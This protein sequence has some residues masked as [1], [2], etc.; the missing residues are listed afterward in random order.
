MSDGWVN[1]VIATD[2]REKPLRNAQ[3]NLERLGISGVDLRLCDGLSL[4]NSNEA[5]TVIIAGMGGE[6]IAGII[7]RAPWLKARGI[8]LILQAMTSAEALRDYLADNGF[9]IEKE[10]TLEE[11]GK[12]YSVILARFDGDM[13]RISPAFRYVGAVKNIT[14]SDKRYIQ[15]Q[16]IRLNSCAES[17]KGIEAQYERY[18]E[19][20]AAAEQLR[21]LM[22]EEN[23][24]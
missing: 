22:E 24:I 14:A 18:N 10:P 5:D 7:E 20:K 11:N 9:F 19:Y 21:Q 4:V 2:L 15:K 17:L 13:R 1:S 12:V 3:E 6:V 16:Y 8:T 23:G